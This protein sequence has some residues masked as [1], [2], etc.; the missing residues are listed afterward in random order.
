MSTNAELGETS[1]E[2]M[3][4]L[5]KAQRNVAVLAGISIVAGVPPILLRE[6]LNR[7]LFRL[8]DIVLIAIPWIIAGMLA[9]WPELYSPTGEKSDPRPSPMIAFIPSM[10]L[11][12]SPIEN[13]QV[14][15]YTNLLLFALLPA[16]V[17]AALV[18]PALKDIKYSNALL[19]LFFAMFCAYGCLLGMQI[20]TTLDRSLSHG[21]STQVL[22]KTTSHSR[23]RTNHY[24]YLS[25]WKENSGRVKVDVTESLWGS[26]KV[27]KTVCIA[28][29][30]GALHAPWYTVQLCQ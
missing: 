7:G 6:Y 3:Q 4:A 15:S 5:K 2:R 19:L 26:V 28:E 29:H 1:G 17:L 10:A 12:M 16:L 20:D 25:P 22:E 8:M 30:S 27:G 18:R 24:L 14:G 9:R 13:L 21:C 11:W 23:G